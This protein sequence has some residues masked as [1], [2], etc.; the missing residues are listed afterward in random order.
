VFH[1]WQPWNLY[2]AVVMAEAK[3][4]QWGWLF[5]S[6]LFLCVVAEKMVAKTGA[7]H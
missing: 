2:P 4:E 3:N 1:Q 5:E 7:I 6:A